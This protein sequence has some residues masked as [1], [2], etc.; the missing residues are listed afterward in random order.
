M[1]AVCPSLVD[2]IAQVP[3][4]R[5]AQGRRHP[6]VAVLGLACAALLCG[7][8]SYR[9]MAEWGRNYGPALARALGFTHPTTPCAATL[10]TILRQVDPEALE[11]VVGPWALAV[12]AALPPEEGEV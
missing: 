3:D 1:V 8:R 4:F 5:Q 6:L 7:A 2:V 9:A 11:A 12:L 10:H